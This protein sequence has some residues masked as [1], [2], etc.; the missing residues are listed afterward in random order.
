MRALSV[1]ERKYVANRCLAWRHSRRQEIHMFVFHAALRPFE[2][3]VIKP[4]APVARADTGAIG[5]KHADEFS[6]GESI[7]Y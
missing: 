1:V 7:S 6:A 3:Y 4:A 5:I 2:E